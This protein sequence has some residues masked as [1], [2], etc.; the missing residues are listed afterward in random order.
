MPREDTRK[1]DSVSRQA[2]YLC[3]CIYVW[4]TYLPTIPTIPTILRYGIV[5]PILYQYQYHT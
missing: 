1:K 2:M 3:M 4:C 5:L